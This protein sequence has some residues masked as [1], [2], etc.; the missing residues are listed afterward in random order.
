MADPIDYAAAS[1]AINFR[2]KKF[3]IADYGAIA[4]DSSNTAKSTNN[5][6]IY[7]AFNDIR[8]Q[9]RGGTLVI[10]N[11]TFYVN[12]TQGGDF[13]TGVHVEGSGRNSE[14]FFDNSASATGLTLYANTVAADAASPRYK[15]YLGNLMITARNCPNMNVA[16][17]RM[18]AVRGTGTAGSLKVECVNIDCDTTSL[19][20]EYMTVI[21]P[22]ESIV[23]DV[24]IEGNQAAYGT[25]GTGLYVYA[26]REAPDAKIDNVFVVRVGTGF[27]TLHGN[28]NGPPPAAKPNYTFEGV[29][30]SDCCAVGVQTGLNM[31]S[32]FYKAPGY[33]WRG[34]H[35]NA[36]TYCFYLNRMA[37]FKIDGCNAQID[38]NNNPGCVVYGLDT[39]GIQVANNNFGLVNQLGEN[40]KRDANGNLI[41]VP[42]V[43]GVVAGG[44]SVG[45]N[46]TGNYFGEFTSASAIVWNQNGGAAIRAGHNLKYGNG[47][48]LLAGAV[49]DLG[50]NNAY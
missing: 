28:G 30:F 3:N 42:N 17:G 6:A 41:P 50:G 33:A 8:A 18:V 43:A 2:E 45:W 20:S 48:T 11:D 35:V 21:N 38:Y 24:T 49:T 4:N 27:R 1:K 46:V 25:S 16:N 9:P 5:N 22:C 37:H 44:S 26:D 31:Y 15:M 23:R 29:T 32:G 40:G 34:G 47:G 7:V 14:L 12:Q 13:P 36:Q 39:V 10:P 19:A